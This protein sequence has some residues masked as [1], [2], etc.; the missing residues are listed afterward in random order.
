[1]FICLVIINFGTVE[2]NEIQSLYVLFL[3]KQVN[4]FFLKINLIDLLAILLVLGTAVKS[5]QYGFH[6]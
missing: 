4:F 1:M 6:I 5:A 2:F 3:T